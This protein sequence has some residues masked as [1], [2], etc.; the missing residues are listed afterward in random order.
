MQVNEEWLGHVEELHA[1]L[2]FVKGSLTV[3]VMNREKW[4]D[5]NSKEV[6]MVSCFTARRAALLSC[7][8]RKPSQHFHMIGPEALYSLNPLMRPPRPLLTSSH[9][10]EASSRAKNCAKALAVYSLHIVHGVLAG[11]LLVAAAHRLTARATGR[12]CSLHRFSCARSSISISHLEQCK[13]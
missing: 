10:P 8:Q 6:V 12:M 7:S 5:E 13:V 3:Q 9:C 2:D 11:L 1:K 4:K